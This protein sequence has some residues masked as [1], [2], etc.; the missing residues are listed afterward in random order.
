MFVCIWYIYTLYPEYLCGWDVYVGV[1]V[2]LE[3]QRNF[4]V[5]GGRSLLLNTHFSCSRTCFINTHGDK[6]KK[7]R[8]VP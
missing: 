7:N 3:P 6:R 1:G 8:S 2:C 4:I 5:V